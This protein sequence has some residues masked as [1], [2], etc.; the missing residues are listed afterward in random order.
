[1]LRIAPIANHKCSLCGLP[2]LSQVYHQIFDGGNYYFCCQGCRMVFAMLMAAAD[3]P[4][5]CRFKETDLYR[6]CLSAG[7]VPASAADLARMHHQVEPPLVSPPKEREDTSHALTLNI[8]VEGMW[9]PACAW[10]I[11]AALDNLD[12][13]YSARCDFSTDRLRCTYDPVRITPAGIRA[14]MTH[15]GYHPLDDDSDEKNSTLRREFVRMAICGLLSV[16]IMMLSWALYSGFF[17]TLTRTEIGYIAWPVFVMTTLVFF[18]GGG[19]ILRKAWAGLRHGAPGMEALIIMGAGSAYAYSLFHLWSGSLHLYFDTTAML[20][21]LL[22]LGKLLESRAK[23]RVRRDLEGFLAL[24]PNKVNLVNEADPGGRYVAIEQ[25]RPGDRFKVQPAEIVP[26][27]GRVV[28]GGGLLDTSAITGEAQPIMVRVGDTVTSGSCVASGMMV[29]TA[30]RVGCQALLGEM[31]HIVSESL[32]QRSPLETRTDRLLRGFVPLIAA[33][34]VA[35]GC[36][37]FIA[38][39]PMNQ[40]VVRAVTVMVI[41]CPCALG[42]AIPLARVA[43]IA[44]AG[45][46]GLLVRDYDAFIQGCRIDALVLDKTGTITHGQWRLES[47]AVCPPWSEET[48]VALALGLEASADH[49]V[50]RAFRA[51]G[52]Q[53]HIP[54]AQL[55][56]I[57]QHDQGICGVYQGKSVRIGSLAFAGVRESVC[58]PQAPLSGQGAEPAHSEVVMRIDGQWAASFYFGDALRPGVPQLVQRLASRNIAVCLISGDDERITRAVAAAAGIV[59]ARGGLLP[60]EK[61]LYIKQLQKHARC[62]AMVGD[63]INDAPALACADLGVAIH[64]GASL[65]QQTASVTLMRSDPAQLLTFIQWAGRVDRKVRQNLWCAVIYNLVGIPVAMTGLLT[66][67]VAASAMLLSSLTVIGNTLR[68]AREP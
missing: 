45:Q 34:A 32:A 14:Q 15:M 28:Q 8:V 10:V 46:R 29:I 3:A 40:A 47:I 60:D 2:I 67:L 35:T 4:D 49:T 13:V 31:I 50:A 55:D 16:N 53:R 58:H 52:R 68:L 42:I 7:V 41:A 61:A 62:V 43:G 38:G 64:D 26:A 59:D 36:L 12:G 51:Y 48:L 20:I 23:L 44:G 33:L 57:E 21:S 56:Q 24:Q 65:A 30:E 6:Q 9:C 1:M 37:G 27:D 5:P 18:Y 22:L 66:P 54:P 19:P 63:G 39:L 25:L 17:T 11:G